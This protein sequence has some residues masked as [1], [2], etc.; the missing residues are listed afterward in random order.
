MPNYNHVADPSVEEKVRRMRSN[1]HPVP[2][3]CQYTGL[4]V[5][6]VMVILNEADLLDTN[7]ITLYGKRLYEA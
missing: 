5:H 1:G 4:P 6:K 7:L 3:I 2:V